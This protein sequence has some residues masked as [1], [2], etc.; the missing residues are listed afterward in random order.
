MFV[1][2]KFLPCRPDRRGYILR[3][4]LVISER[5]MGSSR[6]GKDIDLQLG[7]H[8]MANEIRA[9]NLG[10]VLSYQYCPHAQ[11]ILTPVFE[12]YAV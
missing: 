3:S 10:R 7:E 1:C 11:A 5:E 9:L 8:E 2:C 12:S 6:K 4:G